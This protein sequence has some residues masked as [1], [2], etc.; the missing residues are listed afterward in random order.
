MKPKHQRLLMIGV[1]MVGLGIAAALI[2]VAFQDALV[3]FYT[4]SDLHSKSLSSQQRIRVGGIVEPHSV[5]Q[6][7]GQTRFD[8]TDQKASLAVTY[9]GLLPDLFREGQGIVVE[10]YLI[11]PQELK[12]DVVLAKHDETYMPLDV[13]KQIKPEGCKTNDR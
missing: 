1:A 5:F 7:A 10:G 6:K 13:A 12:A 9:Q 11:R 2:L 4:P 8:V 3:F